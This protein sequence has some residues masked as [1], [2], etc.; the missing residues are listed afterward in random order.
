MKIIILCL[1]ILSAP[2]F[3]HA[4][5]VFQEKEFGQ[6]SLMDVDMEDVSATLMDKESNEAVVFLGDRIGVEGWEVVGLNAGDM[7]VELGDRKTRI[8]KVCG[9]AGIGKQPAFDASKGRR[10]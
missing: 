7:T 2:M 8:L 4:G 9:F 5:D 10:K 6:I 1:V 3:A